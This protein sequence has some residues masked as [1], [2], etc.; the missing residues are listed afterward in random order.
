MRREPTDSP[1]NPRREDTPRTRAAA[2]CALLLAG[3]HALSA[4]AAPGA[5]AAAEHG[6]EV[7]AHAR[8]FAPGEVVRV[9]V[10]S[11]EPLREIAATFRGDPLELVPSAA[12]EAGPHEWTG[13]YAI[14]LD[15]APGA[16]NVRARGTT[17]DGRPAG[18][19]H[20]VTVGAKSFPR[21]SLKV[22]PSFVNPPK[23]AEERIAREQARLAAIYR[24]VRPAPPPSVPFVRPV[25][26]EPTG[27]FGARR[28]FNGEARKPHPGL[29]LR[30]AEG[31]PVAC[32]GPGQVVLAEDLYFSGQT[33]IVD[34][35][36][37]LF[38]IY[39][40]LSAIEVEAGEDIE[41][42]ARLG[43]S[44]ATGRVTGPHLHWG[45]KVGDR[46]FDPT[47]LLDPALFATG[48]PAAPGT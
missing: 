30:A 2:A 43:L 20:R 8:A 1:S 32:S 44:G 11:T 28:V 6:L 7:E 36:A 38:T 21:Q 34:H 13:W 22:A 29:D 15:L 24:S 4:A 47:S 18:G 3:L 48:S 17:A 26:G 41:A 33:V 27:V 16:A 25:P 42:G 9:V 23:A 19:V 37:G 39:A 46:I 10:R 5:P 12:R 40:H 35:G 45:G 14:D 31:T